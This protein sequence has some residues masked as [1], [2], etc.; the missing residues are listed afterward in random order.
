[1]C[2]Q[3][4]FV[5]Q[6]IF[7]VVLVLARNHTL[8]LVMFF[9]A[10]SPVTRVSCSPLF[11]P[12]WG[13]SRQSWILDCTPWI[14]DSRNWIPVLVRG[15]WIPNCNHKYSQTPLIRILKGLQKGSV[16]SGLNLE[17]M[18][19]GV[20]KAGFNYCN[21]GIPD[22]LSYIPDF[23]SKIFSDFG[24]RIPLHEAICSRP[25][26]EKEAHED[27]RRQVLERICQDNRILVRHLWN[28][29][30]HRWIRRQRHLSRLHL[31]KSIELLPW[32][33]PLR[34]KYHEDKRVT[35]FVSILE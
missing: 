23:T 33:E 13:N 22:S 12:M 6:A 35:E 28:L 25:K 34:A 18:Q 3:Q 32:K 30:T 24:I 11:L 1:M 31:R 8:S 7:T 14:P 27:W 2:R 29:K 4:H 26:S 9:R 10:L 19:A 21:S 5:S 17:K 20:R 16:L 15:I